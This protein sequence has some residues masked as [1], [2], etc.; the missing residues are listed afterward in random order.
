MSLESATENNTAALNR[1]SDLIERLNAVKAAGLPVGTIQE[2][3]IAAG[4]QA[5]TVQAVQAAASSAI[6]FG[7]I[8]TAFL[9][10]CAHKGADTGRALLAQFKLG[11]LSEA[12]PDA[13]D[14][15]L[16]AIEAA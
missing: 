2:A 1:L 3:A 5:V 7:T 14:A 8:R 12:K 9:D 15:L 13:F 6:E 4:A 11:K 16:K 10:L